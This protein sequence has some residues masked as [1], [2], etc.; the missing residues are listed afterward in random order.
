[1]DACPDCQDFI[2]RL[3]ATRAV[4]E[5]AIARPF[6]DDEW[7]RVANSI[8]AHGEPLTPDSPHA[9]A[10]WRVPNGSMIVVLV[11]DSQATWEAYCTPKAKPI[12]KSANLISVCAW[13][14]PRNSVFD[15][16]PELNT[17]GMAITHSACKSHI[18]EFF[19]QFETGNKPLATV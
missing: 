12:R 9:L 13:C 10:L 16:H 18:E 8:P 1:M 19:R 3:P 15:T 4:M 11:D 5:R 7:N 2:D 14:Y 17:P 6:T